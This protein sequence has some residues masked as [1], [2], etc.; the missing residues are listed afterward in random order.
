MPVQGVTCIDLS[1]SDNLIH[2]SIYLYV[3]GVMMSY[4]SIKQT[5]LNL[6][7]IVLGLVFALGVHDAMSGNVP[8]EQSIKIP[9]NSYLFFGLLLGPPLLSLLIATINYFVQM[10]RIS[11]G[12]RN[13]AWEEVR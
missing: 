4:K 8:A 6:L 5:I 9:F 13:R 10:Y 2:R 11:N 12:T 1:E 7:I 3:P